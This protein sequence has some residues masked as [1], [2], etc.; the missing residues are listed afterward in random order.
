MEKL[1]RTGSVLASIIFSLIA[2][3]IIFHFWRPIASWY[4]NYRPVL[5]VDFYNFTSYVSY[6]ARHFVFQFN[7]WKYTWWGGGPLFIDYPILHAYLIQPL[8]KWFSLPQSVQLYVLGAAF[9]FL[10]FAY[11][12]FAEISGDRVLAVVLAIATG[13]SSGIYGAL[14]WAG[15]LQYYSTQFFLPLILWVLFKFFRTENKRYFYL[16]SLFLGI[17]FLAHPLVALSYTM[18][19]SLLLLAA[20]SFEKEK[21]FSVNKIKRIFGYFGL[22]VLVGYPALF[23][24]LG[25]SPWETLGRI[26][27]IFRIFLKPLML[28]GEGARGQVSLE[29]G[30]GAFATAIPE[31]IIQHQRL[32]LKRF[33]SDTHQFFWPL[34]IVAGALLVLG[35]LIRKKRTRTLKVFVYALPILWVVLYNVAYAYGISLFHGDWYRAFWAFPLGLGILISFGWGEFWQ[36]IKERLGAIGQ[37][38]IVG[39]L[40]PVLAGLI[41]LVPGY[42][43]I[44]SGSAEKMIKSVE[45]PGYRQQSSAFPDSLG[46]YVEK[47]AFEDLKTRLTP[48]WLNPQDTNYR[49]YDADQRIN[50]WW[51]ALFDMPLAKG[52]VELPPGDAFSGVFYWTSIALTGQESALVESWGFPEKMAYNNALFLIDWFSI[53][54][55]EAEHERSDSYNPITDYLADSKIF[56]NKEKVVVPGWAQLYMIDA[57]ES[58]I[59]HPD[60]E[61]Y[62][63]Y[64]EVSDEY[65]SPI[66]HTTDAS[67]L[68]FI[69]K[70]QTYYTLMRGLAAVNL[71]SRKVIP[72][73]LGQYIDDV[74]YQDL[75]NMDAVMLYDY[76]YKNHG[77]S[78]GKIEKYI[79]EGGRVLI[80]TGSD[81][82]QTDSVNLPAKYPQ[83]L[84]LLFPVKMTKQAELG[85]EWRLSGDKKI[86]KKIDLGDF[87][88]PLI[89]DKPW[90]FSVPNESSALREGAEV[91]LSAGET[92]LVVSWQYGEGVVIWSGMNL[93]YHLTTHKSFEEAEFFHN[94]LKTMFSTT[95]VEYESSSLS[96]LSPNKVMVEGSSAKGVIFR[97]NLNPGWTAKL[98]IGEKSQKLKLYPAGMTYYGFAYARLP[99]GAEGPFLV[100]FSYRGE[101]WVY[102]WTLASLVTALVLLD[103]I[104]FNSR[105]MGPFLGKMASPF[106]KRLSSWWE[107]EEEY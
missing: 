88:P 37:R 33:F 20:Y 69:G 65:V 107:K 92:P 36:G 54:Y 23:N 16:A 64:Y 100:T 7:G 94:L 97:E 75:E 85:T 24:Y 74:S 18:P 86:T 95:A 31:E 1:K 61:E 79:Q 3:G 30:E 99:E 19:I 15:G 51:N 32:Q 39:L 104:I 45:T 67:V 17:S 28:A 106:R 66:G 55:L 4:F 9:L 63:T 14:F 105:L 43:L 91:L 102:F 52:Y 41:T 62:L 71:N 21:F 42:L 60:D 96:R 76:D 44:S 8:L 34:L 29:G 2:G 58:L 50:I 26:P 83:E 53:K 78:W 59:W 13:F 48:S 49:F 35:F 38:E 77:K 82:K 27:A 81:V 73:R 25:R 98:T 46:Y 70:H 89:D 103:K 12:L 11:Q 57:G 22:A 101:F 72:V 56:E 68:G 5:G 10:F 84:P 47:T 90:F 93:P 6:L 87:G 80:E 40:I